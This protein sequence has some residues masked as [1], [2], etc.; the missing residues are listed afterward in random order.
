MPKSRLVAAAL[1]TLIAAYFAGGQA[2]AQK[3]QQIVINLQPPAKNFASLVTESELV[4]RANGCTSVTIIVKPGQRQD[5]VLKRILGRSTGNDI[6]RMFRGKGDADPGVS[7]WL[8]GNQLRQVL[9]D[10]AVARVVVSR[11]PA[12]NCRN[13]DSRK[14]EAA[15]RMRADI[16]A[17]GVLSLIVSLDLPSEE[18]TLGGRA[19]TP[20]DDKRYG[21]YV[22][23]TAQAVAK[24][25]VGNGG[26]SGI[27]YYDFIPFMA[28][29][30]TPQQLE[31]LMV[32]PMVLSF[33]E[34]KGGT[35][36][37]GATGGGF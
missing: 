4:A 35:A 25:V 28:M 33:S 17:R 1:V 5:D 31:R 32:D 16:R 8:T 2:G 26:D 3:S 29:T 19:A 30:V 14:G 27:T 18:A 21:Q 15:N 22:K 9:V 11:Y 34:D 36:D 24:R 6:L 37:G 23:T 7:C 13:S 12:V 20:A 10:P